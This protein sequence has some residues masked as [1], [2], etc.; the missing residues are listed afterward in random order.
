MAMDNYYK[1]NDP[2]LKRFF[3]TATIAG[4][5]QLA[6]HPKFNPCAALHCTCS[7]RTRALPTLLEL[8]EGA[9]DEQLAFAST[10]SL[11]MPNNYFQSARWDHVNNG[12]S[13]TLQ[14]HYTGC[15]CQIHTG[16]FPAG[17]AIPE[18]ADIGETIEADSNY[19]RLSASGTLK[20][21][22]KIS[23]SVNR[24][25]RE[26]NIM[27]EN[28]TASSQYLSASSRIASF[29]AKR[30]FRAANPLKRTK[31][32]T[33]LDRK[34]DHTDLMERASKKTFLA[35][36]SSQASR[37]SRS[38]ESI[39]SAMRHGERLSDGSVPVAAR[40]VGIDNEWKYYDFLRNE[41]KENMISGPQRCVMDNPISPR[42]T[43]HI[44]K[45][46]LQEAKGLPS[47]KR[48]YCEVYLD[49][50]LYARTSAKAKQD[51]CFWGEQF[52]FTRL[53]VIQ[54]LE[55][56]LYR[57]ADKKRKKEKCQLI[58]KVIAPISAISGGQIT[59]RWY[60]VILE[61]N[62]G[63]KSDEAAIRI[64]ARYQAIHILPLEKYHDLIEY[65]KSNY[66]EL[67]RFLEPRIGIKAKEEIA[68]CLVNIMHKMGWASLFLVDVVMEE[69]NVL[70][71]CHLTFRGNSLATK[72]MEAY[73]KLAGNRYL[74]EALG[75][76]V[77]A[78]MESEDD[79]EVDAL[80]LTTD[81]DLRKQQETLMMMVEMTWA[82]I[83]NS[84]RYFPAELR[85][86]FQTLRERLT[87]A[88]RSELADTLIS[89][90]IFLRFLCPAVLSP[91]LF[92]L[93]QEYP[94]QKI[95][96]N[97]TLIAK[98]VQTLA[99]FAKFNGKES[100]ME[101]MN[102]FVEREMP[103]MHTFLKL[104]STPMP[105]NLASSASE[106]EAQVDI[107]REL[108]TLA[109]LLRD[110]LQQ[111]NLLQHRNI[112]KSLPEILDNLTFELSNSFRSAAVTVNS[113]SAVYATYLSRE[114][115]EQ[116][117]ARLQ[118]MHSTCKDCQES[119][120]KL[121]AVQHHHHH[122][123][124]ERA[125]AP[126][127]TGRNNYLLGSSQR[128]ARNLNTADDYVLFSAIG[129]QRGSNLEPPNE[130]KTRVSPVKLTVNG[131]YVDL[132]RSE[133]HR[134][135]Q[136]SISQMSSGYQS[137]SLPAHNQSSLSC[138]PV[139]NG[140]ENGNVVYV[141]QAVV[142][143]RAEQNGRTRLSSSSDSA[144]SSM[145]TPPRDRRGFTTAPRTNPHYSQ[146]TVN[147]N[148]VGGTPASPKLGIRAFGDTEKRKMKTKMNGQRTSTSPDRVSRETVG[149]D[150]DTKQ[151]EME[152]DQLR[153][154]LRFL[155]LKLQDAERKLANQEQTTEKVISDWKAQ[156]EAGEERIKKEQVEKDLQ[157]KSI[158][159]R[160]ISVEEE[161]R[162]EQAE[163]MGMMKAKQKVIDA[164][165][166]KIESLNAA[167]QRLLNTLAQL[168]ENSPMRTRNGS[169]PVS[170]G[171]TS[172][173]PS[174]GVRETVHNIIIEPK[175][176]LNFLDL[177]EI[178]E[179]RSSSC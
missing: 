178:K 76:L 167:N 131:D 128:P 32:V 105:M 117:L 137:S 119:A 160:L 80:K 37:I 125:S 150:R 33:K 74:H 81:A 62:S 36:P 130:D 153:T 94:N 170:G 110:S 123:L 118:N 28:A 31:S 134:G 173:Y 18:I 41:D 158:V 101:F 111:G 53:P 95:A 84:T 34:P 68:T 46:W 157:M 3:Q 136:T 144:A 27:P 30:S 89:G 176:T 103:S 99:N 63:V 16:P 77:R 177:N 25:E 112:L 9:A 159:V 174:G 14:V 133:H 93:V 120:A 92:G 4:N 164:Q 162:R 104:I 114:I 1:C 58:G 175:E 122:P 169:V 165:E 38:H 20:S 171:R 23:P 70:D 156:V 69:L 87:A 54:T 57:E 97:L 50:S 55:V 138:S 126:V 66:V 44:L 47:K 85:E 107:G 12:H 155:Q 132:M 61:R 172:P 106:S 82:K 19:D 113:E 10:C 42:R 86:V 91:N 163:L 22:K 142:S 96:R 140:M 29:F 11:T 166:K 59:E 13:E 24:L 79:C 35:A 127:N 149:S 168:K 116:L 17:D 139:E 179:L 7:A 72:S 108:S 60:P 71:D 26:H 129:Q 121:Q 21:L 64:K 154:Q 135:S 161:L 141:N 109:T 67:C 51:L 88:G 115:Q 143:A 15:M 145:S 83:M 39:I 100:Y 152:I 56:H 45:L 73:M 90:C 146:T 48:Y 8:S 2:Q 43:D 151:Y 124:A 75:D 78:I 102:A 98:T 40:Y 52:E 65:L 6:L 148:V 49:Q 147:G 5:G